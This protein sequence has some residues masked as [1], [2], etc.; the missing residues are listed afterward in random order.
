MVSLNNVMKEEQLFFDYQ[1]AKVSGCY[2]NLWDMVSIL[3]NVY[4]IQ[5][6][7]LQQTM[8]LHDTFQN[9]FNEPIIKQ[10]TKNEDLQK[11]ILLGVRIIKNNLVG[12][13][14]K[15]LKKIDDYLQNFG[16]FEALVRYAVQKSDTLFFKNKWS[17]SITFNRFILEL[18]D[19]ESNDSIQIRDHLVTHLPSLLQGIH[20]SL[21]YNLAVSKAPV[22]YLL[23]LICLGNESKE[24]AKIYFIS[25]F[26]I[27]CPHSKAV[28]LYNREN[29][30]VLEAK[31]VVQSIGSR[32]K[33]VL[34]FSDNLLSNPSK[35]TRLF[36]KRLIDHRSIES[37]FLF[38]SSRYESYA[39]L[40]IDFTKPHDKI[41]Y[42]SF[43][44]TLNEIHLI[45]K[46]KEWHTW[47]TS[48]P[49]DNPDELHPSFSQPM[50][51]VFQI[52]YSRKRRYPKSLNEIAT[53]CS[54]KDWSKFR[55][56]KQHQTT[57]VVEATPK[58]Y[59][60]HLF[61]TK[62]LKI[63]QI[64]TS[65]LRTTAW[66]NPRTDFLILKHS[67]RVQTFVVSP[68]EERP[69]FSSNLFYKV[70]IHDPNRYPPLFVAAYLKRPEVQAFLRNGLPE[71][72]PYL[73]RKQ[74]IE[75]VEIPT[76]SLDD[77]A[78][79]IADSQYYS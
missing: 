28:L 10:L 23:L 67:D 38:P 42:H 26:S 12:F 44:R 7:G 63:Q 60:R 5:K 8:E 29:F 25:D 59:S 43:R 64:P 75:Q 13:T 34:G 74:K 71:G 78:K 37:I 30:D 21:E 54:I 14:D 15:Y 66:V 18:L 6:I 1:Q 70:R 69:T 22:Y 3:S 16:S 45:S 77:Q 68:D 40:K 61:Y 17:Q 27:P 24:D 52:N 41:H 56:V 53:V 35:E 48:Q 76:L 46:E 36:F 72:I 51:K 55:L 57:H 49:L 62:F 11:C 39:L 31:S 2:L 65:L 33:A 19:I 73:I 79:I 9:H 4:T 58:Q 50:Y 47:S 20:N 32:G